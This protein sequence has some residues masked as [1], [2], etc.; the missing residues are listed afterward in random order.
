MNKSTLE[1]V[2]QFHALFGHPI[3]A[4]PSIEDEDT[5]ALRIELIREE[6]YELEN[7]LDA[8]DATEVLDALTDL[9]YVLDGA[10]LAFGFGAVKNAAFA[11]VH[12]SN[13]SKLGANGKP[14]LRED[15]KVLKGE[16]YFKPNLGQFVDE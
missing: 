6:L 5:N 15:G 10:Y 9:Q 1:S 16:N 7:A 8:R 12:A 4:K 11:E 2:E 3:N 13:M 14:I